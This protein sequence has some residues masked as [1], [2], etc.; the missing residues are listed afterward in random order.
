MRQKT[1]R[2][3][4]L[5]G[6][7]AMAISLAP[8]PLLAQPASVGDGPTS[9]GPNGMLVWPKS[10][11]YLVSLFPLAEGQVACILLQ[12]PKPVSAGV[13]FDFSIWV[14]TKSAHLWFSLHGGEPPDVKTIRL[15]DGN[16]VVAELPVVK[17]QATAADVMSLSTNLDEDLFNQTLLPALQG[18]HALTLKVGDV[19]YPLA[20]L[21]RADA[22]DQLTRC[23]ERAQPFGSVG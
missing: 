9:T 3:I 6:L 12:S 16:S 23:F 13:S 8:G 22:V 21:G 11:D 10:G 4:G 2:L 19:S 18:D 17:R 15:L 5:G 1:P 14:Q 7:A 20:G